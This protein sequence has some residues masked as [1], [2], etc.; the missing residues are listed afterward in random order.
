MILAMVL[1]ATWANVDWALHDTGPPV[2]DANTHAYQSRAFHNTI[3][4]MPTW[5]QSVYQFFAYRSHY[6]LLSYQVGELGWLLMGPSTAAPV[7][8]MAPFVLLLALSLYG[9]TRMLAGRIAGLTAAAMGCTTPAILEYSRTPYVDMQLAA[10]VAFATWVLLG[11]RCFQ[12]RRMSRWWGVALALGMLT[13][14]T[15]PIYV[16]VPLAVAALGALRTATRRSVAVAF[17]MLCLAALAAGAAIVIFPAQHIDPQW[18]PGWKPVLSWLGVALV[19]WALGWILRRASREEGAVANAGEALLIA[20]ILASPYYAA[21]LDGVLHK[22]TYQAT[23]HVDLA[24]VLVSNLREESLWFFLGTFWIPL[25]VFLGLLERETRSA[26]LQLLGCFVVSNLA[27]ALVPADPRY[28][29]PNV[30]FL[31]PT[32]LICLRGNRT[33][34]NLAL[35]AVLCVGAI[36][37]GSHAW[38][39]RPGWPTQLEARDSLQFTFQTRPV[40]PD[41]PRTEQYPFPELM[42]RLTWAYTGWETGRD[43]SVALVVASRAEASKLQPRALLYYAALMGRH[44]IVREI[45]I[46]APGEQHLKLADAVESYLLLYRDPTV[47]TPWAPSA[48]ESEDGA[49]PL[50]PPPP[51]DVVPGEPRTREELLAHVQERGIFPK[52]MRTVQVFHFGKDILVELMEPVR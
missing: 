22:I 41:L 3:V 50:P 9:I 31:V 43:R 20:T 5:G 40:L 36:Q 11:S 48:R 7:L 33:V 35:A 32:G 26:T 1:L 16:A 24:Q 44:L 14:W 28:V 38:G 8:G 19:A 15:L 12:D 42:S 34:A 6:P 10:M 30:A 17:A 4:N 47:P 49:P 46:E 21:N 52:R 27:M 25:G 13:K 45:M 18:G 2:S 51:P 39:W 23:V 29:L 37:A